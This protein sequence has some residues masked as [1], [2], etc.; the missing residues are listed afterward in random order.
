M[1][2]IIYS[3]Y[4]AGGKADLFFLF[5]NQIFQIFVEILSFGFCLVNFECDAYLAFYHSLF[6][7]CPKMF[8]YFSA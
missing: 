6:Y 2:P 7:S 4:Y 8:C 3:R 1:S 5:S